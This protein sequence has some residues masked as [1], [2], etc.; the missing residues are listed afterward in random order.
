MNELMKIVK[1]WKRNRGKL[2]PK[3]KKSSF[4]TSNG[5]G[6]VGGYPNNSMTALPIKP[7]NGNSSNKTEE[8]DM[9]SKPTKTVTKSGKKI[10]LWKQRRKRTRRTNKR[11]QAV[12]N[13]QQKRPVVMET[14][15][16]GPRHNLGAGVSLALLKS[17]NMPFAR[18]KQKMI[19]RQTPKN[20]R[21]IKLTGSYHSTKNQKN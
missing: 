5:N 11:E 2:P 16:F 18:Y 6:L 8:T 1:K 7:L 10:P 4:G 3:T 12:H 19:N 13:K 20:I 21:K 15:N 14:E 9:E 17:I